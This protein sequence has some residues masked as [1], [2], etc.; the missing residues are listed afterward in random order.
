MKIIT[1]PLPPIVS[2][3]LTIDTQ[4]FIHQYMSF[5]DE[6]IT[7]IN[8]T[9]LYYNVHHENYSGEERLSV[10][11]NL[12]RLPSIAS[13]Q[14]H[15]KLDF[16]GL[17]LEGINN[18]KLNGTKEYPTASP[19]LIINGD[20]REWP[21]TWISAYLW[22]VIKLTFADKFKF[23]PFANFQHYLSHLVATLCEQNYPATDTRQAIEEQALPLKAHLDRTAYRDILCSLKDAILNSEYVTNGETVYV[24]SMFGDSNSNYDEISLTAMG[25]LSVL[26]TSLVQ[27]V[28]EDDTF[29]EPDA[30]M[31]AVKIP[32]PPLSS[33]GIQCSHQTFAESFVLLMSEL[34]RCYH[35]TRLHYNNVR[36]VDDTI[37]ADINMTRFPKI[38][39]FNSA[40]T[41]IIKT[42]NHNPLSG[43]RQC[44][45]FNAE[46]LENHDTRLWCDAW[47]SYALIGMMKDYH[48]NWHKK[49]KSMTDAD[50]FA[51]IVARIGDDTK[52][53]FTLEDCKRQEAIDIAS[54]YGGD[55]R[56]YSAIFVDFSNE[57]INKCVQAQPRDGDILTC[58][59][60][61]NSLETL[62]DK[63]TDKL[64][65][66]V[67]EYLWYLRLDDDAI[68][69]DD[70]YM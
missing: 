36:V 43:K 61:T 4:S 34:I 53:R 48:V 15:F 44:P 13:T 8:G 30:S 55:S 58:S 69:H 21:E 59:V 9:P 17:L 54:E 45:R 31:R 20:M 32:T 24:T 26:T 28:K 47:L 35:E 40:F 62:L 49:A 14:A 57:I 38:Y 19:E 29:F 11:I 23:D 41:A 64:M 18:H 33:L 6:A 50:F 65:Y 46:I 2:L 39:P 68:K 10:E 63:Y 12:T 52:H 67:A 60:D 27:A 3:N 51:D 25:N 22:F 5:A 37:Y 42:I 16:I 1:M 7:A 66:A 70:Y 56:R